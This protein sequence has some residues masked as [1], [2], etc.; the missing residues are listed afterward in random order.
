MANKNVYQQCYCLSLPANLRSGFRCNA[1]VNNIIEDKNILV[2][3]FYELQRKLEQMEHNYIMEH[4]ERVKP[5]P[6]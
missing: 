4:L 1:C 5:T 3:E 2:Q 6:R